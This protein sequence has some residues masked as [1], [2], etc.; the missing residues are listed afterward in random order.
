MMLNVCADPEVLSAL[1]IVRIVITIIKIV[2]PIILIVTGMLDFAHATMEGDNSK[3]MG[4][5]VKRII[6]ALLVFFIPTFVNIIADAT[7]YDSENFL[8]CIKNATEEGVK[9][10]KLKR[11]ESYVLSAKNT[12]QTGYYTLAKT[13]VASLEDSST[14]TSLNNQL[15]KVKSDLDEAQKEREKRKKEAEAKG[16][17]GGGSSSGGSSGGS[18]TGAGAGPVNIKTDGKYTKSEIMDMSEEQVKSMTKQQ[19]IEFIGAAA[20]Y[21]YAE[22]GGVLPS[23]TIAQAC[24]ES[25]YGKHFETTSHNVYGLIGYPGSK[26]KVNKLR[27]FENFYEATYYH[28]AYFQNYSNVYGSFLNNCAAHQPLAAADSLHA[29]AG[30]SQTYA[31]SIKSIINTNNLTQYDY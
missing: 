30:G 22:Y 3:V 11:A 5:F 8:S 21:V 29:Y 25:G 28:Y 1:R 19:F 13:Y 27:K 26:P 9:S 31:P 6:A 16:P 23:I 12:L 18:W 24:L 17:I 10:A 7:S 2:V 20:R 14:K 15:A 4:V